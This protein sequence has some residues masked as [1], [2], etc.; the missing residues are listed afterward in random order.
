MS[1]FKVIK[2]LKNY[3]IP[4]IENEFQPKILKPKV[5]VGIFL[6]IVIIENLFFLASYFVIPQS[7]FFADLVGQT[8]ADLTNTNRLNYNLSP[9]QVNPLLSKAA[10]M[11]AEDM[12]QKGYFD[13]VSLDN[14]TPWD[15]LNKVGYR[16]IYAGEN[17]AINYT[18]SE[19]VVQAWLNS[20]SHRENILNK[21]FTEVGVGIA[22]G[23]YQGKPAIFIV[24]MFGTPEIA[25]ENQSSKSF[26]NSSLPKI[27]PLSSPNSI[28]KEVNSKSQKLPSSIQTIAP[29]IVVNPNIN[30]EIAPAV[31]SSEINSQ[32]IG[33]I[34]FFQRIIANPLKTTNIILKILAIVMII[35]LILKIFVQIKIQFPVLIVN[36][37]LLLTIIFSALWIN[38]YL[39]DFWSQII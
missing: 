31:K 36:G 33:H 13:H 17:L 9:L 27:S 20:E 3:F 30:N 25:Y 8:I 14:I 10:E 5:A 39:F 4:N 22:R 34:S 1:N 16:Y 29:T 32:K 6:S 35:A 37:T 11:K 7:K 18:D 23:T 15:W 26:Q 38:N 28:S 12:V 2:N 21:N 19:E 24:Q